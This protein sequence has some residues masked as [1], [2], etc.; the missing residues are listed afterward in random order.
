MASPPFSTPTLPPYLSCQG[1]L[2]NQKVA[3]S[4]FLQMF[5]FLSCCVLLLAL[6]PLWRCDPLPKMCAFASTDSMV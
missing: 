2:A 6:R 5:H 3:P 4:T 1:A